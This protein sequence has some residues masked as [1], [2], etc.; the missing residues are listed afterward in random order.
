[1]ATTGLSRPLA[2]STLGC[3][4]APVEEI[5]ALAE[6]SGWR[7]VELRV[8]DEEDVHIGLD[9]AR[10]ELTRSV[11][12]LACV[13]VVCLASYVRLGK[14]DITDDDCAG[15]MLAHLQLARDL[16]AAGVRVFPGAGES[17]VEAD[18]RMVRRLLMVADAFADAEVALLLE[19]H[20]SHRGAG[21]VARVLEQVDHPAVAAIWDILHTW[22]AGEAPDFSCQRLASRLHHVQLKNVASRTDLTPTRLSTGIL[23]VS[24]V[25]TALDS[26]G[27]QGWLSLEWERR[28][29]PAAEPLPVALDDARA[30]LESNA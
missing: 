11:F 15:D 24:E 3:P 17:T 6:H 12:E 10:R 14:S 19:T 21:D 5:C 25:L 1:M 20:D 8:S 23:P 22:L 9:A 18:A 28:W 26:I 30:W 16:G 2:F 7:G 27:Y 29:H 4:G 13:P